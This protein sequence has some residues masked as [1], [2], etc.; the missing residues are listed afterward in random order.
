MAIIVEETEFE[1]KFDAADLARWLVIR[2]SEQMKMLTPVDNKSEATCHWP[3]AT[4]VLSEH[5]QAH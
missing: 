4:S 1:T 2:G 3:R 5:A